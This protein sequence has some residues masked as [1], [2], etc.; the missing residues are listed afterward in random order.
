[1]CYSWGEAMERLE[2]LLDHGPTSHAFNFKLAFD[3]A[4]QACS[5]RPVG[6]APR[7]ADPV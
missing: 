5:E 2:H 1:M 6:S 7:G 3:P 4:G